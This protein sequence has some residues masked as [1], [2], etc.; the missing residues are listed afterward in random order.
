[1]SCLSD[2]NLAALVDGSADA[3]PTEAWRRQFD[4]C[5][6]Y[7][8]RLFRKQRASDRVES[9]NSYGDPDATITVEPET[10]FTQQRLPLV[11]LCERR[12]A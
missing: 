12:D 11:M 7:A 2:E 3:E 5:D 6:R 1:M 8:G 10:D 9:S 4:S